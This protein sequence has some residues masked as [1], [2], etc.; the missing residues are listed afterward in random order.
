MKGRLPSRLTAA[1]TSAATQAPRI[2]AHGLLFGASSSGGGVYSTILNFVPH[3]RQGAI[4]PRR[5][6]SRRYFCEQMSQ[7]TSMSSAIRVGPEAGYALGRISMYRFFQADLIVLFCP[8]LYV[9]GRGFEKKT[10]SRVQW[11]F[12]T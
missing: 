6:G 9:T 4:V 1:M 2:Q 12:R 7:A 3:S 5:S 10:I 8:K 11:M